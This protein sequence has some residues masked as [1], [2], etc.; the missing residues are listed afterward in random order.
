MH[1]RFQVGEH[2]DGIIAAIESIA[3]QTP[4]KQGFAFGACIDSLLEAFEEEPCCSLRIVSVMAH[5]PSLGVGALTSPDT[6]KISSINSK[7]DTSPSSPSSPTL[8]V[9]EDRPLTLAFGP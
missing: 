8:S 6:S 3:P 1:S 4:Q 5:M 9:L 2:K 7:V